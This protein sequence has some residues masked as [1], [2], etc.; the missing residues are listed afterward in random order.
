MNGKRK[1]DLHFRNVRLHY[2]GSSHCRGS[3]GM[4]VGAG[5]LLLISGDDVKD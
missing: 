5:A 2:M 1:G 3:G 4:G